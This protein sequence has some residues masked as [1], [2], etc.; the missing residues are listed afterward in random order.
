MTRFIVSNELLRHAG[1]QG[2]VCVTLV[3]HSGSKKPPDPCVSKTR[4]DRRGSCRASH[5]LRSGVKNNTICSLLLPSLRAMPL[6]GGAPTQSVKGAIHP[7][8]AAAARGQ[9]RSTLV[10]K[11]RNRV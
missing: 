8:L 1:D 9:A 5:W 2:I 10:A 6:Q 11:W 3:K 4:A 7:T